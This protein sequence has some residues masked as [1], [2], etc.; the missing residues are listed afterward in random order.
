MTLKVFLIR[1]FLICVA[2]GL[3]GWALALAFIML[4]DSLL[5]PECCQ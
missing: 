5:P 3:F 1:A 2:S 4:R